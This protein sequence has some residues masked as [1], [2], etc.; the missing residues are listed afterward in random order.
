MAAIA[1]I[2]EIVGAR[3]GNVAGIYQVDDAIAN[4]ATRPDVTRHPIGTLYIQI[5][6]ITDGEFVA[7]STPYVFIKETAADVATSTFGQVTITT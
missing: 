1:G 7:L 3:G 4:Y 6:V 2:K 5:S